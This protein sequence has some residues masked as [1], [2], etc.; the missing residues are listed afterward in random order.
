MSKD[1]PGADREHCFRGKSCGPEALLL[2]FMRFIQFLK[3]I[4]SLVLLLPQ[5]SI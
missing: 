4:H 5:I 1:C 2:K 3:K